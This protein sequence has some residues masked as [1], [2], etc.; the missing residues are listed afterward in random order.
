MKQKVAAHKAEERGNKARR[1]KVRLEDKLELAQVLI[2]C[3]T[4]CS[5]YIVLLRTHSSVCTFRGVPVTPLFV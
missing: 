3:L 5:R 1:A 2:L 4:L